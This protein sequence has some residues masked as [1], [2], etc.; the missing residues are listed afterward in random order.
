MVSSITLTKLGYDFCLAVNETTLSLRVTALNLTFGFH[1][2]NIM[3]I[4]YFINQLLE[5]LFSNTALTKMSP[6]ITHP[7]LLQTRLL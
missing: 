2:E 7:P 3:K 6:P 5:D 4:N 1:I